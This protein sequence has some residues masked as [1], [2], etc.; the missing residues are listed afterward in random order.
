VRV[1]LLGGP[2]FLGRV[3][4]EAALERGLDE[5]SPTDAAG[6]TPGREAE[7]V[8]AWHGRE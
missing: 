3:V 8:K 4:A 7:L 2:R 6:L 5:A 1:L